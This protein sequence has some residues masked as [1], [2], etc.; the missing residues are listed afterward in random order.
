VP[1]DRLATATAAHAA[2]IDLWAEKGFRVPPKQNELFLILWQMSE[3]PDHIRRRMGIQ[4][5][6]EQEWRAANRRKPR[7]G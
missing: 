1:V 4:T 6:A 2:L 3:L 5:E 7:R